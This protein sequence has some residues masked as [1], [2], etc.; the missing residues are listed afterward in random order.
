[1]IPN[2]EH[3]LCIVGPI[4]RN[5]VSFSTDGPPRRAVINTFNKMFPNKEL[6]ISSGSGISS[7]VR[8]LISAITVRSL[9]DEEAQ[10]VITFVKQLKVL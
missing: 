6:T 7:T 2:P 1:M 3:W 9:T 5:D 8:E 10:K 4:D